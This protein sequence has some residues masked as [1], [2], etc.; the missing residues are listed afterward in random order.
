MYLPEDVWG[1]V[2]DFM[3][4]WKETWH[5]KLMPT[6]DMRC[7]LRGDK[8]EKS[9]QLLSSAPSSNTSISS[10]DSIKTAAQGI[11]QPPQGGG[12]SQT[13]ELPAQVQGDGGGASGIQGGVS[14]F[15]PSTPG[16]TALAPTKSPM[17]F[18][19]V[20]SNQYLSVV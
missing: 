6:L 9:S 19:D 17:P 4:D 18:I 16:Y 13:I 12:Q 14:P 10:D 20:I 3:F 7:L 5:K 11:M 1:I 15:K 8:K 2:K